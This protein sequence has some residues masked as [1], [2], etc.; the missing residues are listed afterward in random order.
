[1]SINGRGPYKFLFDTGPA[2]T[3]LDEKIA[4]QLGL[5]S[6]GWQ[7]FLTF[8][9]AVRIPIA[10]LETIS[11]GSES[12]HDIKAT[13]FDLRKV[14]TLV[15]GIQGILGQDFLSK[16]NYLINYRDKTILLDNKGELKSMLSGS[17]LHCE[18]NQSKFYLPVPS[19]GR[20]VKCRRFL[21]D[22]GADAPFV[23]VQSSEIPEQDIV[24]IEEEQFVLRTGVG[25]RKIRAC[26][27]GTYRV[28]GVMFE[29]IR[30]MI[31]NLLVSE[32]KYG[33]GLLPL[34]LF[35][36]VY[37]DNDEDYVMLN[38]TKAISWNYAIP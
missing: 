36:A 21:L 1:V 2:I 16:H 11:V 30:F 19:T 5:R 14:Y 13:Y 37:F 17:R 8:T 24:R 35:D 32:W 6:M 4:Q 28:G 20:D 12:L 26:R 25:Q 22:S 31:A 10:R 3:V 38:P 9:G 23:F 34:R 18:R 15:Y 27:I 7:S 33:D 29:N